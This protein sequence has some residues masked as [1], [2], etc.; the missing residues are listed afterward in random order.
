MLLRGEAAGYERVD[1]RVE[2]GAGADEVGAAV[3]VGQPTARRIVAVV[4]EEE[5]A[6]RAGARRLAPR[7]D[8]LRGASDELVLRHVGREGDAES[9]PLA[10][11][12]L[13]GRR[14]DD[15]ANARGRIEPA[16]ARRQGPEP[17]RRRR[18]PRIIRQRGRAEGGED[19]LRHGGGAKRGD[20]GVD[21]E[22]RV[23]RDRREEPGGRRW[24]LGLARRDTERN[25][26]GDPGDA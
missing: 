2:P 20:V 4:D 26:R 3:A 14:D 5:L 1:H 17:P 25:R 24:P 18:L 12:A 22:P 19:W 6:A 23:A 13:L 16:R 15:L 9:P 8:R 11:V 10:R 7:R 21:D